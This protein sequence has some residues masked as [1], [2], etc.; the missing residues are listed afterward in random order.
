MATLGT[1]KTNISLRLK[2]EDNVRVSAAN[3][4]IAINDAINFYKRKTFWFNE[5]EESITISS[6]ASTFS[7]STNTPL[8]LFENSGLVI[9]E[10][11]H[12]WPLAKVSSIE[13]DS[14]NNESTGRP[15][16]WTYRND[17]FECYFYADKAYTAVGRG[18][19]DYTALVNVTDDANSND[20]TTEAQ[21]LIEFK[22]LARLHGGILQDTKM[23]AYY[24]GL[25]NEEL[26]S[27]MA[28]HNEK[29]AT[30]RLSTHSTLLRR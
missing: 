6:G 16:A 20:W 11:D 13:Y 12:R 23:E 28:F 27:L 26:K 18:I 14:M 4:V 21:S 7:F 19:K 25:A 17:A 15:Y 22:A 3:V 24:N 29:N 9:E 30:G 1:L 5:F 2:D 10:N 8:Y